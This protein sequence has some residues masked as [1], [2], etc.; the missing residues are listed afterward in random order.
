MLQ[1]SQLKWQRKI[2]EGSIEEESKLASLPITEL[3][4]WNAQEKPMKIIKMAKRAQE[5]GR[6]LNKYTKLTAFLTSANLKKYDE[7]TLLSKAGRI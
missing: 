6:F 3:S 7:N 4:N 1:S 5:I 2:T